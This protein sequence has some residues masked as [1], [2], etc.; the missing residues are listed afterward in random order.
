MCVRHRL[1]SLT[2]HMVLTTRGM[3]V[4]TCT[5][6]IGHWRPR[7]LLT[8]SGHPGSFSCNGSF[9]MVYLTRVSIAS[10]T[11][12][13]K[14]AVGASLAT[15]TLQTMNYRNSTFWEKEL[16][17][18]VIGT[19]TAHFK[20]PKNLNLNIIGPEISYMQLHFFYMARG[21]YWHY[22]QTSAGREQQIRCM[23]L[24][25]VTSVQHR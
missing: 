15:A 8:L 9:W 18:C 6:A 4:M 7:Y 20:V 10:S 11:A 13:S 23:I 22:L 19:W 2:L 25:H 3:I 5:L 16:T 21:A 12:H 17:I 1:A 14:D 24:N